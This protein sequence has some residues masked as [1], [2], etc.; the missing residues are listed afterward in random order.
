M[1]RL[2][3]I[4]AGWA[5]TRHVEAVTK[6][7]SGQVTVTWLVDSDEAHL[8][9]Q[10]AGLGI[11]RTSTNYHAALADPD[12]DAVSIC[13]PHALH[14]RAAIDAAEAG[15]HILC[16]KPLA[17][18]VDEGRTML[19]AA[20]ANG[21]RLYVAESAVYAPLPRMLRRIVDQGQFIG[22]MT[23]VVCVKGFRG[24]DYG[25]PGRRSWLANPE[26][27]GSGTWLLHGI[28]TVA[29]LRSVTVCMRESVAR[30]RW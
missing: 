27:G 16:E 21:V 7:L 30:A 9:E 20:E 19:R 24:L 25:Y 17:M 1:L 22:E 6:E 3:V 26:R 13:L 29:T 4:G 14:C 18:S 23:A 12:L 10:A 8:R 2:A 5:G 15:K 11:D 28:H